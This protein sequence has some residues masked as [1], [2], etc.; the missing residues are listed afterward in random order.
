M[1]KPKKI[2]MTSGRTAKLTSWDLLTAGKEAS[3][4]SNG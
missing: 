2:T 3:E 4:L 1:R